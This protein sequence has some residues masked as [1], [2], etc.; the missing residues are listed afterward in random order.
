MKVTV[1]EAR[2]ILQ[3]ASLVHDEETVRRSIAQVATEITASLEHEL[4]LVLCVMTGG[5]VFAGQLLPL[6]KFP[7]DLDYLHATRYNQETSGKALS[8]RA[9]PCTS[10]HSSKGLASTSPSWA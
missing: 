5:I 2:A 6:L 1:Q 8:W 9:M 3:N 4:P 7:L 10:A